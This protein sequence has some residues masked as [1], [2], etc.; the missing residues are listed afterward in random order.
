MNDDLENLLAAVEIPILFVG[1]DSRIRRFNTTARTLLNLD[2]DSAGRPLVEA[3]SRIDVTALERLVTDV[4]ES[5]TEADVE[6]Q[7]SGGRWRLARIRPYR[8]SDGNI[9]GAIIALVD[10]DAFKRSVLTAE[11][12]TRNAKNA[13]RGERSAGVV[14]RL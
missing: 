6:I 5:R 10:I 7:E 4:I 14:T 12:A 1:V 8:T 2:T 9:D 3:K 13:G 11:S